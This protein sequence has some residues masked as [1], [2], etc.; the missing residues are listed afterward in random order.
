MSS[1][2]LRRQAE[3]KCL[4]LSDLESSE[5]QPGFM[6][7]RPGW[8]KKVG[9]NP[10]KVGRA[11]EIYRILVTGNITVAVSTWCSIYVDWPKRFLSGPH[12]HSKPGGTLMRL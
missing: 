2:L 10:V 3:D 12:R 9:I 5:K 1:Q 4:D 11:W 8:R 7:S 6:A